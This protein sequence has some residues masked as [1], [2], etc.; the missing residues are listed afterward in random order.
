ML[1]SREVTTAPRQPAETIAAA[2]ARA[3]AAMARLDQ[4]L[5][6][7]PLLPAVLYRGQL[8]WT[9]GRFRNRCFRHSW[10]RAH[11]RLW[12]LWLQDRPERD[13]DHRQHRGD[14]D[15]CS[16]RLGYR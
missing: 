6:G 11:C 9:A 10:R 15:V 4:A 2:L 1:D 8:D 13:G 12:C 5:A 16:L 3:A 7:H 14:R